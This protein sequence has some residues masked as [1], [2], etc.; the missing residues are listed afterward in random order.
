MIYYRLISRYCRKHTQTHTHLQTLTEQLD[1]RLVKHCVLMNSGSP[2]AVKVAHTELFVR[3][4]THINAQ[5]HT[6]RN[7]TPSSG[8]TASIRAGTSVAGGVQRGAALV[9]HTAGG[10]PLVM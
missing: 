3:A 10:E 4:H 5:T 9:G 1:T 6:Y 7:T 2:A 8:E